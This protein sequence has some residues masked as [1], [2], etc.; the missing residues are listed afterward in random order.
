MRVCVCV[1]LWVSV[2]VR[3]CCVCGCVCVCGVCVCVCGVCVCVCVCV[4]AHDCVC[5]CVNHFHL[6]IDVTLVWKISRGITEIYFIIIIQK[7][8]LNI[9][10]QQMYA[11][12]PK[13]KAPVSM[14]PACCV[15]SYSIL[16]RK[17]KDNRAQNALSLARNAQRKHHQNTWKRAAEVTWQQLVGC[18]GADKLR[19]EPS[20][21]G[22]LKVSRHFELYTDSPEHILHHY[23]L[24]DMEKANRSNQYLICSVT[25]ISHQ[26]CAW[27]FEVERPASDTVAQRTVEIGCRREQILF[28]KD[29]SFSFTIKLSEGRLNTE[30]ALLIIYNSYVVRMHHT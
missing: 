6:R 3:V 10:N 16:K 24:I 4:C 29:K 12:C 2:C 22:W 9:F 30:I 7:I 27:S 28:E 25:Q 1:C 26:V 18:Q 23:P 8:L 13:A 11:L 14:I 20:T 5:A 15:I 21:P 19:P 17:H